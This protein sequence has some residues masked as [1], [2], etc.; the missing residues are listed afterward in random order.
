MNKEKNNDVKIA[1]LIDCFE[2]NPQLIS[3]I[4]P[5]LVFKKDS[6]I[7]HNNYGPAIITSSGTRFFY[8]DGKLI[9]LQYN[10]GDNFYFKADDVNNT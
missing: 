5:I 1:E 7:L 4:K 3:N 9:R 6:V 8:I 10:D 2:R